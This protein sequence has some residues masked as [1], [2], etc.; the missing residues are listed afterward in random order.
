[1][2]SKCDK[3]NFQNGGRI[4]V[5]MLLLAQVLSVV[6]SGDALAAEGGNNFRLY[7]AL[8]T[9]PCV[10]PPGEDEIALNFG[11][12]TVQDLYLSSRTRGQAFSIHL[13]DCDLKSV[14]AVKITFKGT[15]NTA[16]P[17]LLAIDAG[18]GTTGI[19]IGLETP[20]S[21]PVLINGESK[22]FPLR[23]GDNYIPFKAYVRGEPLA[24]QTHRIGYGTF[25]STA[26]FGLEYE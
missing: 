6:V 23:E 2:T 16:L 20:E 9:E 12:I 18:S 14:G 19:A 26:T 17:G 21:M 5:V 24:V 8:V 11:R 1:M 3:R 13:A 7:G 10:I 15:E 25:S 4:A 22:V